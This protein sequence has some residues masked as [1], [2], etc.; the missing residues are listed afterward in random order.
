MS[1][2]VLPM[3]V[4]ETQKVA[5]LSVSRP[6]E[7]RVRRAVRN[8]AEMMVRDLDSLVAEDHQ[9]RCIWEFLEKL[10]LSAFYGSVK[11]TMDSPGRPASDPRVLLALWVYATAQGVGSARELDRLCQ[12]HDAYR[13]LRGGVPVDYHLLSDFRVA[14]QEALDRLLTEI[15]GSLMANDLVTLKGVAQ[16]GVKVRAGAGAGSF[17]RRSK[18][19]ECLAEAEEQVKKLAQEH[20][21]PDPEVSRREQAA[22]ERSARERAERVRQ[23]LDQMSSIQAA[24]E[25]QERTLAK[26]KRDKITEA[27]VSTT[28]SEARVMKMPDGGWRPAYNV[29]LATDV[30]SGVIVG[31]AVVNQGN[32]SGQAPPMEE[33]VMQ[34]SGVHPEA[35]LVD[36]GYAQREDIA[37]L[38]GREVTVYAP[39]RPPR[40][41]T[42]GRERSSPRSDDKP[43]VVAWRQRMETPEAKSLYKMRAATAEW[44]N[45]QVRSHGLLSFTVRGLDKVLSVVL[46]VVIAHNILRPFREGLRSVAL[47]P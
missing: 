3:D 31:A 34:R 15:V 25:R 35:Y 24:K 27:R 44:A 1:Q 19:E 37:T 16:D 9:V 21:H 42:S 4:P 39:V 28:D 43:A 11:A 20:A 14:H 13:W 17:H 30:D 46:L 45:A 12:E 29:Q 18:L 8:Q 2:S 7:V 26:T 33:Q 40:T 41:T 23:A 36:G 22:R 10:D 38:E 5:T 47:M 6:D 32:D